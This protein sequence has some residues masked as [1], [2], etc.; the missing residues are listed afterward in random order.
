MVFWGLSGILYLAIFLHFSPSWLAGLE[1]TNLQNI[2]HFFPYMRQPK[3]LRSFDPSLLSGGD[4]SGLLQPA[5]GCCSFS[6]GISTL[7][8]LQTYTDTHTHTCVS[9]TSC[10]WVC[11]ASYTCMMNIAACGKQCNNIRK[12]GIS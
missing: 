4:H 6:Y 2:L 5:L 1:K 10:S 8:L 7:K 12:C 9:S 11:V 3:L